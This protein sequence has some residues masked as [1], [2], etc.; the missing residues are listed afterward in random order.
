VTVS[1]GA[2]LGLCGDSSVALLRAAD[3]ALYESKRRGRDCVSLARS[4]DAR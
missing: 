4:R 1:V 2:R 3:E